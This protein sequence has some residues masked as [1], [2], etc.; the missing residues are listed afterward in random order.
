MPYIWQD[1]AWVDILSS[2]PEGG[3]PTDLY[4]SALLADGVDAATSVRTAVTAVA[5]ATP[6]SVSGA[7]WVQVDA[8]L[9]ADAGGVAIYLTAGTSVVATDSSTLLEIATG[10]AAS[11]V[12]WAT[13]PIGYRLSNNGGLAPIIVPG[14]IAAGSRVSVRCRSA[15][16]SKSITA[17]VAFLGTKDTALGAPTTYQV[18][19]GTSGGLVL[20]AP[21]SLNTK[22]AWAQLVAS[23]AADLAAL[24]IGFQ[25]ATVATNANGGLL[26]DIGIGG[27]GSEAVLISD[28]YLDVS[29]NEGLAPRSP[30]VYGVEVPAG[31]RLSARY[32]RSSAN[33]AVDL[34]LIGAPPA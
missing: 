24:A 31:S 23:T 30:V 33:N 7:S 13:V 12:V 26:I 22:G 3:D 17:V 27:A 14:H 18:N 1:G 29:S 5:S 28:I 16:A 25:G 19:T 2:A 11:E 32:A 34:V 15:I 4:P 9:S 8:S 10:A 20:T 6:H 21:G